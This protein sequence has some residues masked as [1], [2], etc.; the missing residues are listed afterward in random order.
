[1]EEILQVG[2]AHQRD[3]SILIMSTRRILATWAGPMRAA[4]GGCMRAAC[5]GC[6]LRRVAGACLRYG[7]VL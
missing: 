5:G 3:C 7:P 2:L 6:M 1:V 4:C